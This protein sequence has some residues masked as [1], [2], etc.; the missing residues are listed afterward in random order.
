MPPDIIRGPWRKG[1]IAVKE[2][3]KLQLSPTVHRVSYSPGQGFGEN[4]EFVIVA[5]FSAG[6]QPFVL[7][8]CPNKP[9]LVMV[10][11]K[12]ELSDIVKAAVLRDL[13]RVYMAVVVDDGHRLLTPG[14][15]V[16]KQPV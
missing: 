13:H 15:I 12:P 9:P 10:S 4:H 11:L 7:A 1:H 16:P 8:V 3:L 5:A 6:H 14:Q 2:T